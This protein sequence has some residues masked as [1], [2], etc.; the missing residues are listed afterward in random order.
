[1]KRWHLFEFEDQNWFP[2]YLHDFITDMLQYHITTLELY[3]PAI[4]K[5]IKLLQVTNS[6]RIVD[7]CSGGGG[8]FLPFQEI[9]EKQGYSVSITLSDKYPNIEAFQ[10]IHQL[11]NQRIN[12]YPESVDVTNVPEELKGIRTLFTA[13]HHFQPKIAQKI[14]QDA[15]IKKTAIGIFEFTERKFSRVLDMLQVGLKVFFDTQYIRPFKWSRLFWTYIIPIV[16][17]IYCWDGTVSQLRTYSVE[18]LRNMVSEINSETYYWEMGK[19]E[20][21][22][23]LIGYPIEET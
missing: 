2:Q 3:M 22:T 4:H 8:T 10:K 12:F 16:P 20:Y 23:Y 1:M 21:I 7:L 9:L 5:V 19:L 6:N 18:E 13:F 11:S 17:F 14:L 15:V